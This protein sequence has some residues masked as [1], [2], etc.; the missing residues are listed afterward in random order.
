MWRPFQHFLNP[1][2]SESILLLPGCFFGLKECKPGRQR[3][4]KERSLWDLARK[5]V[6]HNF[7]KKTYRMMPT[8]MQKI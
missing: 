3:I 2:Y 1:L 6:L 5:K 7:E 4:G 8:G